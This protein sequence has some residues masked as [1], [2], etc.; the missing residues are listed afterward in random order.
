MLSSF[1]G[2]SDKQHPQKTHRFFD[3]SFLPIK[4]A[5]RFVCETK[6]KTSTQLLAVMPSTSSSASSWSFAQP[7]KMTPWICKDFKTRRALVPTNKNMGETNQKRCIYWR[8][9]SKTHQWHSDVLV[10]EGSLEWLTMIPKEWGIWGIQAINRSWTSWIPKNIISAVCALWV[11]NII[12][13]KVDLLSYSI[14]NTS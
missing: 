7:P 13:H 12:D 4:K 8:S 9:G 1:P 14:L 2:T 10:P 3:I 5:R 11:L 6:R